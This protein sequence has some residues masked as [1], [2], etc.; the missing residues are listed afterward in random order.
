MS[1]VRVK[2]WRESLRRDRKHA[3]RQIVRRALRLEALDPRQLLAANVMDDTFTIG[4]GS[5]LHVLS[6]DT[7]GSEIQAVSA[8]NIDFVIPTGSQ[9][10][11]FIPDRPGVTPAIP[12][13]SLI[14]GA[15][16]DE[17]GQFNNGDVDLWLDAGGTTDPADDVPMTRLDGMVVGAVR[18]NIVPSGGASATNLAVLGFNN[19]GGDT[20]NV[21]LNTQAAPQNN[22]ELAGAQ[23]AVARFPF[24]AGW[25]SSGFEGAY[26]PPGVNITSNSV[27]TGRYE[28]TV[29]GV[30]DS[31]LDGY[32]FTIASGNSDNYTQSMPLG[33]NRW[34]V[35]RRD[36]SANFEGGENGS[37]NVLYVPANSTGLIGG[38]VNADGLG[39]NPLLRNAGEF[40]I[41]RTSNGVWRMSIPGQ[42]PTTGILMLE[43]NDAGR[44]TPSNAYLSYEADGDD[45]IIRQLEGNTMNPLNDDF[46]VV[47]VPFENTIQPVAPL[48]INSLGTSIDPTGAVSEMGVSL[49]LNADGTVAYQPADGAIRGLAA[50]E[51]MSDTF[52]YEATDGTDIATGTVNVTW[53]G[54]NDAP[55]VEGSIPAQS[56]NEDETPRTFDLA[57]LFDD[58]DNGDTLTY[59]I[60][61]GLG[62]VL[63]GTIDG[64]MLTIGPAPNRFGFTFFTVTATDS[65]GASASFQV[66]ATVFAQVDAPQAVD[67]AAITNNLTPIDIDVKLNDFHPDT[68]EFSVAAAKIDADPTATTNETSIFTVTGTGAAPNTLTI[69]SAP[70]LGD[71][72]VGRNGVNLSLADGVFIGTAADNTSPY[73]TVTTYDAFG[74]YGFST[75]L[76]T[77]GDGERNSPINAAFFPFAE[78]WVSGHV[79]ADGTLLGG[80]GVSA[81][82]ITKIETGLFEVTVPGMNAL[83][84]FFDSG[85]LLATANANADK[86]ISV[87]P[88]VSGG[89]QVRIV[90]SD[91]D[92]SDFFAVGEDHSWSFVYV[93]ATAPGLRGGH[94]VNDGTFLLGRQYGGVTAVSQGG[95]LEIT[96]P[97][98]TPADGTMVAI[99]AGDTTLTSTGGQTKIVPASR[100]VVVTTSTTDNTKFRLQG[101]NSGSYGATTDQAYFVFLPYDQPQEL[102]PGL[103][104]SIT[105]V[106]AT[107]SLGAT[108][109]LNA[110][111]T[112]NYNPTTGNSSITGLEAGESIQDTFTYTLSD[113]RSP[114]GTSTGTVTVTV[115][116]QN[117]PPTANDDVINTNEVSV[118]GARLTVLRNDVDPD[119][120]VIFGTPV[121]IPA[122]NLAVDGS[123]VWSVAQT[124]IAANEITLGT[125]ATGSVEL[126]NAGAPITRADG[127]VLATIRENAESPNTN[128][129]FAQAFENG[130][131]GTSL[132]LGQFGA[133]AAADAQVSVSLFRFDDNWIG[134]HVDAIGGLLAGN[135]VAAGDIVRTAAGSYEVSIPGVTDASIDGFLYVIGNENADNVVST[136]AVA[137]TNRFVV[138]VRDN[139]HDAADREDGGFSFVFVP[140]TAQNLVTGT[141]DAD[142]TNLNPLTL[143]VG[144]FSLVRQAVATGG[145][146][147]K[148]TIPGQSPD[149]GLLLLTNQN[150][151]SP[152]DNYLT[153]ESDGAGSFLIRSHDMPGLGLQNM[154]FTFTFVPFDAAMQPVFR[155]VPDALSISIVDA[156]SALGATLSI[157]PDGTIN[158]APGTILDALYDGDS[159]VDTFSYTM[160]DGFGGSSMATVTINIAGVGQPVEVSVSGGAT[161][162][163]VGDAPIG[164]DPAASLSNSPTPFLDGATLSSVISSGVAAGDALTIRNDG[165]GTGQVGVSGSNVTFEGT[166]IG[167]FIGDG[168]TSSPLIVTFNANATLASAQ[169]VLRVISFGNP[170][171]STPLTSRT[172]EFQLV[173]SNAQTAGSVAKEIEL[174]LLRRRALRQNTDQGFGVYTGAADI[175]L[176]EITPDTPQPTGR[177][178]S[179]GLL[180]DRRDTGGT[181]ETHVLLKF[182]DIF[183][184]APGQ[185]PADAIITSAKLTLD[186]NNSGH[187]ASMH[188]LLQSYDYDAATWN[189]SGA[190]IQADGVEATATWDS[191]F[192]VVNN[193]GT[194]GAGLTA[195]SVLP[196]LMAWQ[197]GETNNGWAMLPW[198]GGTDGWGFTASEGTNPADRPILEIEWLP[199]GSEFS[200]FRQGVNGYSSAADTVLRQNAADA[201][202]NA[203]T[204]LFVD[205]RDAGSTNDNQVLIRFDDIIGGTLGQIPAGAT[206]ISAQLRLAS[207]ASNAPGDGGTFHAMLTDWSDT[208]TWNSLTDGISADGVEAASAA[209]TQAGNPTRNPNAQGGFNEFNVTS[210]VQAWVDGSFEN[211]GWAV[212][213]WNLGTDG[214]AIQS[215]E[216]TLESD[217]P[218]LRVYYLPPAVAPE[219]SITPS[220]SLNEGNSGTTNFDFVVTRGGLTTGS[221]TVDYTFAAGA[222]TADDFVGGVLPSNG[223]VTFVDGQTSAIISIGVNGDTTFEP[224]ESFSIVISNPSSGSVLVGQDTAV[225]TILNDDVED[226]VAP[227][228]S[229]SMIAASIWSAAF[230]DQIDGGGSGGGN[231]LGFELVAGAMPLP[232]NGINRL[233]VQ[234]SEDVSG[235]SASTIELRDSNGPLPI[236]VDY[237][238]LTFMAEISLATP[239]TF[240]KLRLAVS[241]TVQDAAGNPL[242]GDSSG[243]AGGLFDLRFDVLA[244]DADG[245]GRVN[246]ADLT[247]F[248]MAFNSQVSQPSYNARA[249]W[250]GDDRINGSD[251]GIFSASFNRQLGSL[252]DP[253]APFGGSGGAASLASGPRDDF[254]AFFGEDDEKEEDE[255]EEDG[256]LSNLL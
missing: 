252:A 235:V 68:T 191:Q 22:G 197:A 74:S 97:G 9:T 38:H 106:A 35:A 32:L 73:Q 182:A 175:E 128:F 46:N 13:R 165:V 66:A 2:N 242:D 34:L 116:G 56:F 137:G 54:A 12:Q 1:I 232:W 65:Q 254:F 159:T 247:P 80:S 142:S 256:L 122:A 210:D 105:G 30:N 123:G 127:V 204:T 129:R 238:P 84:A 149:T 202:A 24:S 161:Y 227:T 102:L 113:A 67:D 45:F 234:F 255:D 178:A 190:G 220:V 62:G 225:G 173:D 76:G 221:V 118:N 177:V 20:D 150:A 141:V 169:S 194:T 78:G 183:G 57:P 245:N 146:E 138:A 33:G 115:T 163:A 60:D 253:T 176:S 16:V 181:N 236:T 140:R 18:Q 237:D 229:S 52:I 5:V 4:Q 87:N 184:T 160:S 162:Y 151:T 109:T 29:D 117:Q 214:W 189:S 120:S 72:A 205:Y 37:F 193:A 6:N 219:F 174:G 244:G 53:A 139:Q 51:T 171:M 90:D 77:G 36:N 199:A 96:V 153:Y 201:P 133:D 145:N 23:V 230:I 48:T 134:G 195:V 166:V 107:S 17:P 28:I 216:S 25:R 8:A 147:W 91:S 101:F 15:I 240:S 11:W 104:L 196:D 83:G 170:N 168:T 126:L 63:V 212:L 156:T 79:A 111:G 158:Y 200:T 85:M 135:G 154:P 218:M 61:P 3:L 130:S 49:V 164:I 40:T 226:A 124:S 186:T 81:A 39:V 206:I 172:V 152:E 248:S 98:Y 42:T 70:N 187:G 213:P 44:G 71:V 217:R 86:I 19:T 250:N 50:G 10:D 69:Q 108:M 64:S 114:A 157:N 215:S 188:R 100:Q 75:N 82:N 243:T 179:D 231:G 241:D 222:T 224:D 192:G 21:W 136:Q 92:G 251:L 119:L 185:I 233:Y 180:V 132:S 103:N 41:Q 143:G 110:D 246:G 203:D 94:V 112:V 99:Y 27:G 209:T 131:G 95:G 207:L 121:G 125:T 228:I 208:D 88:R 58:L 55:T 31:N 249:N 211:N 148:L 144:E 198:N 47:F 26:A 59:S 43:S 223:Q 167:T 239:L 155:P 7:N 93:P 89:W 14:P